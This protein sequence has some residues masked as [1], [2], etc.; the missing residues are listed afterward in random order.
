MSKKVAVRLLKGRRR[1]FRTGLEHGRRM[2]RCQSVM[3]TTMPAPMPLREA[4]VLFIVQGFDA[5]D[6]GIT[7]GLQDTVREVFTA[8]AP[9]M[10]RL[11][12]ELR[13]NLVLVMNGL[14]VFPAEHTA[15]IDQIREMG[16]RTAIWFADDPYFT[17]QTAF[18]APHYD[19]VFTHE[20]SCIAFYREMGCAQVHYLP[21]AVNT[22]VFKPLQ[23]EPAY[24]SDVCFIGNGFPN[25]IDLFN[26]LTPFLK[27]KTVLIAG[28]LWEQLSQFELLKKGIKL[29]WIPIEESVKYYSGAKIVINVHRLTYD[30]TYNKNSRNLPGHSINPRTY[31]IAGCGTLQITDYRHDLQYYYTPGQDIETFMN[32]EELVQKMQ[33]YLTHEDERQ[34]IAVKGLRRTIAEHSFANRLVKLMDL[35]F[36]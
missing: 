3:E 34:R 33:Y 21:L 17:D 7:Q 25:R 4:R 13:P 14:H 15:H 31:E 16:I 5:I 18:L 23:V 1:G 8:T 20:M 24:R 19:Y 12:D 29:Q 27:N 11:A 9:D 30:E 36:A 32:A 35:V 28:A 22:R 10:L 26:K 2:G 6:Q